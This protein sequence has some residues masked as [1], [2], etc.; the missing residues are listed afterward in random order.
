ML[1][2]SLSGKTELKEIQYDWRSPHDYK[3]YV[4]SSTH[5][6]I[7]RQNPGNSRGQRI[8]RGARLARWQNQRA[9]RPDPARGPLP[10]P[11]AALSRRRMLYRRRLFSL[12]V[13]SN[14][15]SHFKDFTPETFA[16]SAELQSRARKWVRRELQVFD[17]LAADSADSVGGPSRRANN[18]EFLLEYIISILRTVDIKASS[19]RAEELLQDFL[20]RENVRLFLHELNQWLRS[21]YTALEDWDRNVQ[22]QEDLLERRHSA[23]SSTVSGTRQNKGG[24]ASADASSSSRSSAVRGSTGSHEIAASGASPVHRWAEARLRYNPD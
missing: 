20:G 2:L 4:V 24:V 19:G 17:F 14:R 1:T 9:R 8:Y 13:G 11:D 7:E 21:P 23:E 22:Y 12:H 5:P 10:Q 6:R 16:R 18:A 3:T 15:L